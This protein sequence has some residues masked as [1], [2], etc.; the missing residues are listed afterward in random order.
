MFQLLDRQCPS[1]H[2][3]LPPDHRT[4]ALVR[5]PR[6]HCQGDST[7]QSN[8]LFRSSCPCLLTPSRRPQQHYASIMHY[9]VSRLLCSQASGMEA[10]TLHIA[11]H[12]PP[13][14]PSQEPDPQRVTRFRLRSSSSSTSRAPSSLSASAS[15]SPPPLSVLPLLAYPFPSTFDLARCEHRWLG[16][17]LV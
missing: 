1:C 13:Q 7:L 15:P 10:P 17:P 4:V 11:S 14:L 3:R 6:V 2:L 9:P 5:Q 16:S 8:C 12:A